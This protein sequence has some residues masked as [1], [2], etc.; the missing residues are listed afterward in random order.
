MMTDRRMPVRG[1]AATITLFAAAFALA[2]S[3]VV[4]L[5]GGFTIGAVASR[6]PIRPL[7][8]AA[9]L[10]VIARLL[11]VPAFDLALR[12]LTGTRGQRASRLAIVASLAVFVVS[13]AWNTRAAGGSD[14]SCYVLQADAFAHGHATLDNPVAPL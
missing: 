8:V 12:R 2:W 13:T 11:S 10:A 14:S 4:L 3:A 6:D 7:L 1:A 9:I 5:S